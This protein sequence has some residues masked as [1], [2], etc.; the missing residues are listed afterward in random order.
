MV[1]HEAVM[2]RVTA[3]AVLLLTISS[4]SWSGAYGAGAVRRALTL[5]H[6]VDP[7]HE[8]GPVKYVMSDLDAPPRSGG[9]T[10]AA[11][12]PAPADTSVD[13]PGS[14]SGNSDDAVHAAKDH[15]T[16]TPASIVEE[17]KDDADRDETPSHPEAGESTAT[18]AEGD[19]AVVG[20]THVPCAPCD[21]CI[22]DW[23]A[24]SKR[25]VDP[26]DQCAG[27]AACKAECDVKL[28]RVNGTYGLDKLSKD[29]PQ[30]RDLGASSATVMWVDTPRGNPYVKFVCVP[31]LPRHKTV[32]K[33]GVEFPRETRLIQNTESLQK[34]ADFCGLEGISTRSWVAHV[35]G[36]MPAGMPL[37]PEENH[38]TPVDVDQLGIFS[39][40]A[41]GI[42]LSALCTG[43]EGPNL[44]LDVPSHQ[45]VEAALYDFIF[46]A[47][48]R[49]T[50][51]VFVDEDSNIKLIDNDNLLGEQVFE[52][53]GPRKCGV[54]S[55]FVPATMESWRLRRSKFCRGYL[56]TLDYR[57]HVGPSGELNL[58][59]KL[60]QCL[61]HFKESS[62]GD[63][64]AE[65]GLAEL[66]FAKTLKA[67]A[68][69][70]LEVGFLAAVERTGEYEKKVMFTKAPDNKKPFVGKKWDEIPESGD[71]DKF[72]AWRDSMWRPLEPAVCNK[73]K[74]RWD[75]APWD[76]RTDKSFVGGEAGADGVGIEFQKDTDAAM[77]PKTVRAEEEKVVDPP[78]LEK[79]SS[80][81]PAAP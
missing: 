75:G 41:D 39:S 76:Y 52:K 32:C 62:E 20:K 6:I 3:S 65:F 31:G 38:P 60:K 79:P 54:S 18:E 51:N 47:G 35:R 12:T 25:V 59:P 17:K 34:L 45:V 28:R 15:L 74:P 49:H 78:K 58:K 13:A 19:G 70:L 53:K 80:P 36:Q 69:A 71:K 43:V 9:A 81:P 68:S 55:L 7:F 67:R 48:D 2:G 61:T 66:D 21:E 23:V 37:S 29:R 73:L 64:R 33:K 72:A 27:T 16:H 56:G 57:C 14:G 5:P 63:I 42:A 1:L 11:S 30:L 40:P 8:H 24:A 46:C 4:A 50:Q 10:D 22:V 44:L 26:D 77:R